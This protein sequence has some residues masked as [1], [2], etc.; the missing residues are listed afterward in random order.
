VGGLELGGNA[1]A[2]AAACVRR[3]KQIKFNLVSSRGGGIKRMG[4]QKQ[5]QQQQ[6][7]LLL[8]EG[9]ILMDCFC[10]PAC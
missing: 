9:A 4:Q 1:V 6:Q 3:A 5:Q 2:A 7:Q 10:L 8:Q